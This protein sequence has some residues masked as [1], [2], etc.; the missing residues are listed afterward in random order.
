MDA[1]LQ[2][3]RENLRKGRR[4]MT[5]TI[6]VFMTGYIVSAYLLVSRGLEYVQRLPLL[7]PVLAER[8]L[9][10]L[11]FFF[12]V[13]LVISNATITGMSL[14]RRAETG[15]LLSL[16]VPHGS[17]VLWKTMEGLLLSSWG[18]VLLSTP[19]LAAFGK[20][21]SA[22]PSFYFFS[23]AAVIALIAIAAN[24]STWLL[25]LLGTKI[26]LPPDGL[27]NLDVGVGNV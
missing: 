13:M 1:L 24:V 20:T 15:W 3:L 6:C 17:I 14:F 11:F 10:L 7:G 26:N 16:P 18:L 8:L 9:F 19:I 22:G 5:T 27:M 25:L 4:L 12:F 2:R 23:M 21:F